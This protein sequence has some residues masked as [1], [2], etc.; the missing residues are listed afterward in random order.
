VWRDQ[1]LNKQI[2]SV[3]STFTVKF[4]SFAQKLFLYLDVSTATEILHQKNENIMINWADA[5]VI[6]REPERH[7]R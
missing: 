3:K 7:T 6:D 1:D 5:L 4:I 2:H